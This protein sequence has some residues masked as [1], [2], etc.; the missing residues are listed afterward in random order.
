MNDNQSSP[1]HLLLLDEL[2]D[3]K[4]QAIT[5]LDVTHLTD[6]TDRIIICTATS[7][8]HAK[9]LSEKVI[10]AAKS[11]GSPP[12]AHDTQPHAD[13]ILIDFVDIVVHIMLAQTREFYSLE[14]LWSITETSRQDSHS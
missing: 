12:L 1:L 10:S 9:S 11:A 14:K 8:R 7:E 4:A 13:W 2:T 3:N 6:V 5:D